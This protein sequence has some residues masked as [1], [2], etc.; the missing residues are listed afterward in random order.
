MSSCHVEGSLIVLT[1]DGWRM[2]GEKVEADDFNIGV[3]FTSVAVYING[4]PNTAV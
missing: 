4:E 3:E 2:E 1:L